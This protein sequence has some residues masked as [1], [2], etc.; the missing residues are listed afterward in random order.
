MDVKNGLTPVPPVEALRDEIDAP[1]V[2]KE[3]RG[4]CESGYGDSRKMP[5][6]RGGHGVAAG[7]LVRDQAG[8]MADPSAYLQQQR[9][10]I[11]VGCKIARR[12]RRFR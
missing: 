1:R 5:A 10:K 9:A 11:E 2:S 12:L 3:L 6:Y 8:A 4:N 7:A